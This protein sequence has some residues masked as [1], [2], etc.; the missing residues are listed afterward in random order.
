MPEIDPETDEVVE[1][2]S[3]TTAIRA[4]C[5]DSERG[6][7]RAIADVVSTLE[8]K[9]WWRGWIIGVATGGAVVA[10]FYSLWQLAAGSF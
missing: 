7:K 5:A 3:R 9:A 1:R 8:D 6:H 2:V 4:A 10:I